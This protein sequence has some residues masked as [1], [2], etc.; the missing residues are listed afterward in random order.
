MKVF[1]EKQRFNQWWIYA[2][3][4][5]VFIIVSLPLLTNYEKLLHNSTARIAFLISFFVMFIV[6]VIIFIIRLH[7]RIDE[8]GIHYRFTP[9]HSKQH[10][11]LWNDISN[12]YVRKYN[13]MTEYGGYGFRG[14]I[15]KSG[16]KAF[17]VLGNIG[18]QII[19]KNEKKILIGTQ[20]RLEAEK[21]INAYKAK[22]LKS[23]T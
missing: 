22:F 4:G 10:L 17:N 5:G 6:G 3:L 14:T 8:K 15:F 21:V 18:I 23:T 16:G 13:A 2:A 11:I 1:T 7:T 19:L 12:V 20:K 9:F